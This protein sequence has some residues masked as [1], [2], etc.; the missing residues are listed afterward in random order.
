MNTVELTPTEHNPS[1]RSDQDRSANRPKEVAQLRLTEMSHEIAVVVLARLRRRQ[2]LVRDH[3]GGNRAGDRRLAA[4][5][6]LAGCA[7]S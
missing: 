2:I 4:L 6:G 7:G 3:T 1:L 5:I